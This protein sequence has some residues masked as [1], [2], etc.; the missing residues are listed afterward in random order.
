M[1]RKLGFRTSGLRHIPMDEVLRG[2]VQAGYGA[3]EFCLEHPEASP[4]NLLL[5]RELGLHVSAVSYHGKADSGKTRLAMGKRAVDLAAASGVDTVVFGSPLKGEKQFIEEASELYSLC[6]E[7]GIKPA[8]ETEPGTVLDSLDD[9]YRL[10]VPLGPSAGLNLDAGHLHLQGT[11]T[12]FSIGSL[13]TRIHHVHIEGMRK[14]KHEH[15][16]PGTG[17]LNWGELIKGLELAHYCGY[18]VVDLFVIPAEW[19]E[20]VTCANAASCEILGYSM[21]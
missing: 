15:L 19:L 1:S 2:L 5:A 14:G 6:R 21:L 18:I 9:F 16:I 12:S 20:F 17:D 8:W 13:A 7:S 11:C 3:V 10:I 4:E